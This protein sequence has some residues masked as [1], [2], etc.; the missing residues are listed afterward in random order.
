MGCLELIESFVPCNLI[1]N[2]CPNEAIAEVGV[3][4]TFG[5]HR[6]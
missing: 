4:W 3:E 2:T 6:A 1:E 5:A